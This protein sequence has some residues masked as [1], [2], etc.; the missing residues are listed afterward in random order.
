M[1]AV[2]DCESEPVRKQTQGEVEDWEVYGAGHKTSVELTSF[3]FE[4]CDSVLNINPIG[5]MTVGEHMTDEDGGLPEE[6]MEEMTTHLGIATSSAH[7]RGG[8]L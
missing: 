3:A 5:F 1:I 4:V 2:D 6:P 8:A 7:G